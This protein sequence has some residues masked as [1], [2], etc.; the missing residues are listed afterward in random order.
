[1]G[2]INQI[3]IIQTVVNPV[4]Y[5]SDRR[6]GIK[7]R[8]LKI[9]KIACRTIFLVGVSFIMLYPLIFMLS[10]SLKSLND[11]YDPTVIWIP[12]NISFDSFK[13]AADALD[14]WTSF[15]K[16]LMILVPSVLLQLISTIMAAYGFARFNFKEKSVWFGILIF[17]IIVP[18]QTY[19][20]P[21]YVD[22]RYF[23]YFGIGSLAGL[24]TGE[25]ISVN[26]INSL[27]PFYLQ[28]ALGCGIRSGLYIFIMRQFFR[29]MPPELED[30]ALID[31]CGP[32]KTF[33]KVMV[34]NIIPAIAT[35]A[36]FSI[37][38]Y[39]NDYILSGL[40]LN[41]DFPL[42]VRLTMVMS[43][44]DVK[45]QRTAGTSIGVNIL[46]LKDSIMSSACFLTI[47][48][49]VIMYVFAQRYFTESIERTG[50]VG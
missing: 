3:E 37:V 35:V 30:A 8:S 43:S 39:W 5:I 49:L 45:L 7:K 2:V 13:I 24:F 44:L 47:L 19:I 32:F 22:L 23:D 18:I 14:Y 34:P 31:G 26:L 38:W 10:T 40:Y 12:K 4:K 48:P 27:T 36:V 25:K 42:S 9:V 21:M 46:L 20:I 16:T 15:A 1:M 33:I 41:N 29:N 11:T 6:L 17:S 50:I 28:S